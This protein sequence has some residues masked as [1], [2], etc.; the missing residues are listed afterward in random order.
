MKKEY[1]YCDLCGKQVRDAGMLGG[2]TNTTRNAFNSQM[3][4]EYHEIC[5]ECAD[6]IMAFVEKLA[7]TE[8]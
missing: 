4:A 6:K 2:Y 8:K 1:Y 5:Y 7:S 3:K